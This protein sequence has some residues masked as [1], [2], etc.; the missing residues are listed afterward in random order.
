M[1]I[2]TFDIDGV[3][4]F[5][6]TYTGVRPCVNDIIITGRSVHS[7]RE[8]TEKMLRDRGINNM[9]F[10]NDLRRDDPEYGRQASGRFKA[11]MITMLKKQGYDIGMHFEDDEIQIDEI[12]KEHPDL[13]I[14]HLVRQDGIHPYE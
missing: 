4:D 14:V 13:H 1:K 8:S 12:K 3:I 11:K 10:M 2:N 5:G 7:D 6:D 9:L